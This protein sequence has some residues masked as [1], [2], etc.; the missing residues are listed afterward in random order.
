[1]KNTKKRG[2]LYVFDGLDGCGK[3]TVLNSLKEKF[4]S[5]L[6]T[7]EP[8]GSVFAEKVRSIL[9]N[10]ETKAENPLTNFLLFWSARSSHFDQVIL[11]AI[12][13]GIDVFCDRM[14]AST[15]AFQ[16][17]AGKN[18]KLED[19]FFKL[20][21]DIFKI[22]PIYFYLKIDTKISKARMLERREKNHFD[23][24]EESYHKSVKSGY[25]KFFVL[26]DIKKYVRVIDAGKDKENVLN[27]VM[28][29]LLT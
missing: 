25:D 24:R 20:R 18:K 7:R 23:E 28:D 1:M 22:N 19:L 15:Y 9:L 13:K 16:I 14:D 6:F 21:K 4:P 11:P 10:K 5:A 2:K 26:K 8:G 12:N 27:Q 17:V 3:T 29:F